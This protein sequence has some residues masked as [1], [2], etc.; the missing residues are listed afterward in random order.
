[1]ITRRKPLKLSTKPI[2]RDARSAEDKALDAKWRRYVMERDGYR[3]QLPG[4]DGYCWGPLDAH[5][6]KGR[7]IRAFRFDISLGLTCCR[8]HHEW[9]HNHPKESKPI[10]EKITGIKL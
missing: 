4:L 6:I 3:C 7:T 10:I 2:L 9:V 1:M 8:K 5:H